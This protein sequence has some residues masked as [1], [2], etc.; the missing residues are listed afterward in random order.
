MAHDVFISHAD[1]DKSI[2][3][4]ICEKLESVRVR[5]WIISRDI[6]AG[7][8]WTQA[9]RNAIGSSRAV[10]LVL[11]PNANAAPHIQREIAHAFY[12]RR[13][14]IAF[15]LANTLPKRDFLFYLGNAIW[16]DAFGPDPE[17]HLEALTAR[18]KELVSDR[19]N[20]RNALLPRGAMKS[21][22]PIDFLSSSLGALQASHYRT[23]GILKSATIAVFLFGVVWFLWFALR[24]NGDWRSPPGNKSRESGSSAS[25]DLSLQTP[26]EASTP[27]PG[28]TFTRFGLWEPANGSPTPLVQN[29][30]QDAHSTTAVEQTASATPSPS[31]DVDQKPVGEA[32]R[33]AAQDS[34][35]LE[36]VQDDAT[37]TINHREGHRRK[38]WPEGH[39]G[40]SS[41]SEKS[42]SAKIKSRG[43]PREGLPATTR[44]P[45]EE[46]DARQAQQIADL[47]SKQIS[48]LEAQLKKAQEDTQQAQQIADIATKQNSA[49]EAQLKKAQE[50]VQQAQQIADIATKQNSA[51]EAQLKKAQEDA[52][53]AQQIADIA[54]KRN[55]DL[56][57]QLR[58]SQEDAQLAQR[59]DNSAGFKIGAPNIQ[60][61]KEPEDAQP[62]HEDADLA[63]N[64]SESGHIEPPNPSQNAKQ[65]AS[66]EPL[67]ARIRSGGP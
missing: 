35:S 58:K 38:T 61:Q 48:A 5:C 40:I 67:D 22:T 7:E 21:K 8:D 26:G 59:N 2:A 57:A 37:P 50:D 34:A 23:L 25:L 60:S 42:R 47:A 62:A 56:E 27:K 12:T 28:Y 15:R 32:E 66:T 52:R 24:Q 64:Q 65:A 51:L 17:Q 19:T 18:V 36:S 20:T 33:L 45:K 39:N 4:A 54:T 41:A 43:G 11:S 16:F 6:S 53:Q 31:V 14:I 3:D 30:L 46:Q 13:I 29:G 44:E 9:T 10:I 1:K 49:L 55:S 63:A